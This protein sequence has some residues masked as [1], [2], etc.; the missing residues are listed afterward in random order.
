MNGSLRL[1]GILAALV[2][3]FSADALEIDEKAL[4]ALVSRLVA[5]KVGGLIPC[6]S[7]G[8]FQTLTVEERKRVSEV[9]VEAAEARV[10]VVPHTGALTT[11]ETIALSEHAEAIGAA[12][13]MVVPPFYESPGWAELL[14]HYAAVAG[15]VSIP[16]VVYNIPSASGVRM[17]AEQISELA[18]IPGVGFIKDSSGDAVL[19]TQLL[20]EFGDRLQ[21]FNGL[22]SLTFYAF[23][24]GAR[25]S[26]WGAANF[27]PELAVELYR[28]LSVEKNLDAGRALWARI[29]P[30]CQ[31]LD[32]TNYAS[33]VKTA[34]DLL[35][36]PVGPTRAP[37]RLLAD[38]DR[39]RLAVALENAGLVP[40]GA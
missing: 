24:A 25:G 39:K 38:Q 29:W 33:A 26:V 14:D 10:P 23:A 21:V 20:Q 30:V 6:G 9:V 15:A 36:I 4:R 35:G 2:T 1:A 8:E 40:A 27:M 32:S 7:T 37:A 22:D 34:C 3:P 11:R 16:L 17:S 28:V 5:A 13:V 12:A 19:L 18:A 31:V